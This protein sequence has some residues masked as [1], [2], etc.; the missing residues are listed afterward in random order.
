MVPRNR[1]H[2]RAATSALLTLA[3]LLT[4]AGCATATGEGLPVAP[5]ALPQPRGQVV[6][7]G[8]DAQGQSWELD[9]SA[10][11]E[12]YLLARCQ[13]AFAGEVVLDKEEDQLVA[14]LPADGEYHSYPLALGNGVYALTL[15]LPDAAGVLGAVFS[16]LLEV[17]LTDEKAPFL[18][19]GYMVPYGEDSQVVAFA[20]TF[21]AG[22]E[23]EEELVIDA[24]N[25]VCDNVVYDHSLL[26]DVVQGHYLPDLD[27][28]LDEKTGIC[29]DY[30]A[31]LAAVLRIN[32]IP[33]QLVA[34]DVD[35]P[36]GLVYHAW[37]L[38]WSEE[39]D[40]TRWD[41]TFSASRSRFTRLRDQG[42][43]DSY[44]YGPAQMVC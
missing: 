11:S 8:Q 24:F 29:L 4:L 14:V 12:G 7:T 3:L 21:A 16:Q 23:T 17:A 32:G 34:G 28:V 35:T 33:C 20:R 36:G 44:T 26:D 37:N 25:W 2:A 40:W 42:G 31:L 22:A 38:V 30:A 13:A 10:L 18:L 5:L 43:E 19:P 15:Y 27:R 9:L 39:A 41:P 1:T 6:H